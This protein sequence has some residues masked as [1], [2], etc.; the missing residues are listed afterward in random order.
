MVI[1]R[2]ISP[3][4]SLLL[5]NDTNIKAEEVVKNLGFYLDKNLNLSSQINQVCRKGFN[6]LRN[7]WQIAPNLSNVGI[8]IR[9]IKTCLLPHIDYC[10]GLY[11]GLPQKQIKKL[12]R[13][14]NASVR[15]IFNLRR[16]EQVS[17][18]SF[19]MKCHFLPVKFRIDFKICLLTYKCLK[20]AAP[21]YMKE[22]IQEKNSLESLRIHRDQHL[23][24]LPR[25]DTLDYKNR[26]FSKYAPRTWNSLPLE[27]RSS[28]SLAI[29]KTKLKTYYFSQ[30]YTDYD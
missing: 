28:S 2:R 3:F 12:Q 1:S 23:L 29:F 20:N 27:I 13:L 19:S 11:A 14:L 5:S 24:K 4:N 30:A 18:S 22:L 8:K 26:R 25:L 15:F 6:L 21:E 9:I 10:D 16:F 17:I 7:L